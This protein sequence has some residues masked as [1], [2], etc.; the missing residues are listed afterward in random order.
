MA[1]ALFFFGNDTRFAQPLHQ[2][3][4][5]QH[6]SAR[7]HPCHRVEQVGG[8]APPQAGQSTLCHGGACRFDDMVQHRPAATMS[9][10]PDDVA[11]EHERPAPPTTPL[12]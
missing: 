10:D 6:H 8:Q 3:H 2:R 12:P 4:A 5:R 9:A 1:S 11:R 7:H